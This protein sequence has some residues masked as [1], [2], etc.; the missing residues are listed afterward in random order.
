MPQT[1]RHF[2]ARVELEVSLDYLLHLPEGHEQRDDWPLIVFL[3]GSG[4]RGSDLSLVTKHGL[5]RMI[6]AGHSIPAVVLSPQCPEGQLWS[7]QLP[8]I[9][10]L[11]GRLI[12]DHG[13]DA[14]RVTV[15]GL[16]LGGAGAYEL[17]AAYPTL[18]AAVAPICGP[19]TALFVNPEAA[20]VPT[21]VFHGD[22]DTVVS[23]EDSHRLVEAI[24]SH[25]GDPQLT[26]YPGV[27][28]NSW[29]PAYEDSGLIDW[30]LEQHLSPRH[31]ARGR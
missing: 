9:R 28:H 20:Q 19:W 5:P 11:V 12:E 6:A 23:V 7:Q 29:D 4:E 16:S 13:V 17:V 24:R 22:T 15:T 8:A 30:L 27:G 14:G 3:H 25:G 26:I 31:P 21:W 10:A 1:E 18:F 2:A